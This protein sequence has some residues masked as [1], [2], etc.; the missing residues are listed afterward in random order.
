M[1]KELEIE[2]KEKLNAISEG[3]DKELD[4][5]MVELEQR[6]RNIKKLS[7]EIMRLIE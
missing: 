6:V 7:D 1:K 5:L 3:I 4:L 2:K